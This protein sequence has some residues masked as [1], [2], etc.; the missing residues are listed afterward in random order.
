[1]ITADY[2]DLVAG[3][4]NKYQHAIAIDIKNTETINDIQLVYESSRGQEV[5]P[6]SGE[7]HPWLNYHWAS[8]GPVRQPL[9]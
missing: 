3:R 9:I 5:P 4:S 7:N 1:M 8:F 6:F 2:Q